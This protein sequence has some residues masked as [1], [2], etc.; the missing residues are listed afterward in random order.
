M[1]TRHRAYVA[2][3]LA[4]LLSACGLFPGPSPVGLPTPP[5]TP[6]TSP[7]L[8]N[9]G[10]PVASE[11]TLR[12]WLPVSLR[13]DEGSPGGPLLR[14]RLKAFELSHPGVHVEVRLRADSGPGGLRDMLGLASGAAP[15][16]LPD[17][18]ALD[19]AALHA[20]AL[21]G[22]IQPVA[23]ETKSS[24][25]DDWFAFASPLAEVDGRKYGEPF[26]ADCLV[27][28]QREPVPLD[29]PQWKQVLTW[30]DQLH[31]P[32]ADA[33]ARVALL[34][35]RMA[36][37]E[38]PASASTLSLDTKALEQALTWLQDLDAHAMLS[39]TSLQ[40]TTPEL[41]LMA[42]QTRGRGAVTSYSALATSIRSR[43]GLSASLPPAPG[44]VR[45]TLVT[46]WAWATTVT[47][48]E[49]APLVT[50]LLA[51]LGDTQFEAAWTHAQGLVPARASTLAAWPP[52]FMTSLAGECGAHGEA[53]PTEEV[54]VSL[55]P[56]LNRALRQVLLEGAT[57]HDAAQAA[58][59]AL[60][61]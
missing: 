54:L 28:A 52:G 2:L 11:L 22:L 23:D 33:D 56:L 53:Y 47:D 48:P 51:W 3:W 45:S 4:A 49:R 39:S 38:V 9:V 1:A 37:G 30:D 21:K 19:Q 36:G 50:Q 61:P 20:A 5:T 59:T 44:D 18:V 12:M 41:A 40:L 8:L 32:L 7:A 57:P 14:E 24:A 46:G 35:Y 29:P 42:L 25:D 31:L 55:G 26:V 17:I 16:T 15:D 10:T 60:H 58:A 13:P 43:S 34:L 6:T 27:L